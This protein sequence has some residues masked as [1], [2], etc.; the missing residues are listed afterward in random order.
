MPNLGPRVSV[1][2]TS[3]EVLARIGDRGTG[4]EVG[5]MIAPHGMAV[6]SK[7]NIYIGEVALTNRR[8]VGQD[9]PEDIRS[10]QRFAKVTA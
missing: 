7:G 8:L 3:G 1:L 6:D 5:Q 9:P 4:L 10:F 2:N